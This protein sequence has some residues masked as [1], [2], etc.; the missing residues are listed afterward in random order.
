MKHKVFFWL[1]LQDRLSTRDILQR[2]DMH[3]ESYTCDM[4]ILQRLETNAHL[5]LRCN[6]ARACWEAIDISVVTS[7]LVPHT[8]NRISRHLRVPFFMEIIIL[9]A[10]SI[11][12]TRMNGSLI[13]LTLQCRIASK[14]LFQNLGSSSLESRRHLSLLWKPG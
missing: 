12:K 7:R 1:L 4:C 6:F 8:I 11:W 2:K 9:M 5:F 10:W 3:L 13:T 14:D